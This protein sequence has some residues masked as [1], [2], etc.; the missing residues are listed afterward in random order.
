MKTSA[1]TDQREKWLH[2]WALRLFQLVEFGTKMK[3]DYNFNFTFAFSLTFN[4]R[5]KMLW[6]W[7]IIPI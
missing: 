4:T 2:S 7:L 3:R 5:A 1:L 6:L